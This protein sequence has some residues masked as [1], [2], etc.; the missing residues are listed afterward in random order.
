M[1]GIQ[2]GFNYYQ[3]ELPVGNKASRATP[4]K[5]A[6]SSLTSLRSN[7]RLKFCSSSTSFAGRSGRSTPC[8]PQ[9]RESHACVAVD[10]K[11]HQK[12]SQHI[13]V[14]SALRRPHA[15]GYSPLDYQVM[16]D[17]G[18][19]PQQ[20]F[21]SQSPCT[22]YSYA[23]RPMSA[24]TM[25]V[26]HGKHTKSSLLRA[27]S[28]SCASLLR[29]PPEESR[30]SSANKRLCKVRDDY[31]HFK[32]GTPNK[33]VPPHGESLHSF[34]TGARYNSTRYLDSRTLSKLGVYIPKAD[35]NA[36]FVQDKQAGKTIQDSEDETDSEVGQEDIRSLSSSSS[37][38]LEISDDEQNKETDRKNKAVNTEAHYLS[39][40]RWHS[41][42]WK[43]ARKP[44]T[45]HAPRAH[46]APCRIKRIQTF[47]HDY[48]TGKKY[49]S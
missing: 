6:T 37:E 1:R 15:T 9:S 25:P 30:P 16:P 29:V 24:C 26:N 8:T 19:I 11:V 12:D 35:L 3:F 47:Y 42:Q 20:P 7:S 28:A 34:L 48:D 33:Q 21:K 10:N 46:T 38:E 4:S 13:L 22:V 43:T 36:F 23:N 31:R 40:E 18:K 41:A 14:G 27:K 32:S 5:R 17:V 2:R 44:T 45:Q 39:I 49:N